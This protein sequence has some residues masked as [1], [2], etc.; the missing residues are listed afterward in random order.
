MVDKTIDGA[1]IGNNIRF[2]NYELTIT[3]PDGTTTTPTFAIVSDPTS[4]Q[5]Y[6]FTPT[7]VGTYSFNFTFPG[8][9]YTYT[10]SVFSPTRFTK[11]IHRRYLSAQLCINNTYCPANTNRHNPN[12]PLPTAYWTR[13][14]YGENSNWY[15][16]SSNW[17]GTGPPG[18]S[19]PLTGTNEQFSRGCRR[20]SN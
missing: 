17:L 5:G 14:I 13:P 3:A 10:E 20:T 15:T 4:N 6:S 1:A 8:Q 7:Q 11:C 16:I 18:Y 12:T 9:T 2:H 19:V